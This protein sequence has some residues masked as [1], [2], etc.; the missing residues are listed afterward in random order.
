MDR[1]LSLTFVDGLGTVTNFQ[2]LF[3]QW[4]SAFFFVLAGHH[5]RSRAVRFAVLGE[6]HSGSLSFPLLTAP[7]AS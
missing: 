4:T 6:R 3:Q 7:L 2:A 1:I 5:H